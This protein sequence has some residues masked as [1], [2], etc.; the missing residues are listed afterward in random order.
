MQAACST[1]VSTRCCCLTSRTP[2]YAAVR[3]VSEERESEEE[4]QNETDRKGKTT[5]SIY[6]YVGELYKVQNTRLSTLLNLATTLQYCNI[7]PVLLS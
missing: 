7:L 3:K 1:T 4:F 2:P 6:R 5:V